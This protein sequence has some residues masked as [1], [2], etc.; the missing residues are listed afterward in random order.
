MA[1]PVIDKTPSYQALA[2][3]VDMVKPSEYQDRVI[4]LLFFF[5]KIWTS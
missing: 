1:A 2:E 4:R 3:D 5:F